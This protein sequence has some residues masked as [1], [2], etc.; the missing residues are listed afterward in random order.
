[1][2]EFISLMISVLDISFTVGSVTLTLGNVVGAWL[3]LK[4]GLYFYHQL[5]DPSVM[6]QRAISHGYLSYDEMVAFEDYTR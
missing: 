2:S 4:G 1:M 5:T 3:V 6:D